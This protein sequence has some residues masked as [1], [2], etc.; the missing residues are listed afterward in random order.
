MQELIVQL[1]VIIQYQSQ[2]IKI[3][4]TLLFVKS[5][6]P[7]TE[8]PTDKK[9][10]KLEIDELPL[11]KPTDKIDCTEL[12]E[13]YK[14]KHKKPLKP[15]KHRVP[16]D[17]GKDVVCPFC[18]AGQEYF[19]DNNGGKGQLLCK[20]CSHTFNKNDKPIKD[21][22]L[23]CP[24]C[25]KS[26]QLIKKR[27]KFDIYKCINDDCPYYQKKLSAMSA[28][29]KEEFSQRPFD[30]KVRYIYRKFNFDLA[31]LSKESPVRAKVDLSNIRCSAYALGLI[32]T[33][34]VNYGIS[35]R[36]VAAIMYDIHQLKISHQTILNYAAAVALIVKPFVDY[37][38]YQLSESFCGDETYIRVLGKW[39]YIFFF[40][41]TVKKII[42]SYRVRTNRDC[43]SA[44]LAINDVLYKAYDP[45]DQEP[46][47]LIVD[48]NPIYLLARQWFAQ[49][50]YIFDITQVIGLTNEDPV[51]KQYR[52]S[53]QMIERLNRT[54]KGNYRPTCGF[55]S[56]GGSVDFVT[57]FVTYFN[58]L[59]PHS[60]L[61]NR[62]PVVIPE[63][64]SVSMPN[65]WSSLVVK[66]YEFLSSPVF[67]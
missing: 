18:G 60:A 48:G 13:L 5:Y 26:I 10:V 65:A 53:K 37:Y 22:K 17:I 47:N 29:Q 28:K 49:Q 57:L 15:V 3:L 58:F 12:L 35:A 34:Y 50:G 62:T 1:L 31:P 43:E 30:F 7:E 25:Q 52:P 27:K 63:L 45:N 11:L 40:F 42:I 16:L 41:D 44:V 23:L 36:K 67:S 4:M 66:A 39:K 55:N 2:I 56:D 64:S 20:V 38:P 46:L 59:R 54:F 6:Q 14:Q 32:L 51:S 9:Y 24:H 33:Y 8:E 21:V 61:E 19:Y